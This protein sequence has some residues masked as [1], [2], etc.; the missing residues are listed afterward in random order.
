MSNFYK[1]HS[2]ADQNTGLFFFVLHG[3]FV[4]TFDFS[5]SELDTIKKSNYFSKEPNWNIRFH[6]RVIGSPNR[7]NLRRSVVTSLSEMHCPVIVL[8]SRALSAV[9]LHLC[10]APLYLLAL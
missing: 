9:L 1:S 10:H 5:S 3:F 2:I 8:K 6:R 7:R 4:R